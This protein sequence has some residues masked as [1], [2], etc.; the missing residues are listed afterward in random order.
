MNATGTELHLLLLM[1][2]Y[3]ISVQE[4]TG[5]TRFELVFEGEVRLPV[6]F[7]N[8]LPPQTLPTE[9]NQYDTDSP[10]M[11]C[12]DLRLRMEKTYQQVQE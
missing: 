7:M 1:L 2:A 11:P 5:C 8:S 12:L 4:S 10:I 3:H 6:Y 9:V